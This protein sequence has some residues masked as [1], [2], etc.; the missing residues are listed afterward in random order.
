MAETFGLSRIVEVGIRVAPTAASATAAA[1]DIW[2]LLQSAPGPVRIAGI[3]NVGTRVSIVIGV[4]LGSVEEIKAGAEHTHEVVHFISQFTEKL[5]H[6]DPAFSA[7]PDPHSIDARI[8]DHVLSQ[9]EAYSLG[10]DVKTYELSFT[11]AV[12]ALAAHV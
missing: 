2:C 11:Q 9:A 7:I 1:R 6:Y 3:G 5:G 8:A 12:T 4:T 10:F